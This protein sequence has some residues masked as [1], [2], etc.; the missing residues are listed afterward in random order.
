MSDT[1]IS[2]HHLFKTWSEQVNTVLRNGKMIHFMNHCYAT[3]DEDEITE[4]TLMCKQAPEHFYI[5]KEQV[6]INPLMLNPMEALRARLKEE[7]RKEVI[8]EMRDFGNTINTGKLEGIANSASIQAAAVP[9]NALG[10]G[11][12]APAP[13]SGVK[14]VGGINAVKA[15]S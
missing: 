12:H 13:A 14:L 4:L 11:A 1:A 6:T 10:Q 15:G 5:D 2:E 7:A 3:Q 9:S 8:A